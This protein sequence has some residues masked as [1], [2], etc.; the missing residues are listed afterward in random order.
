MATFLKWRKSRRDLSRLDF[1]RAV[2]FTFELRG[3]DEISLSEVTEGIIELQKKTH[4][5]YDFPEGL[6]YCYTLSE[7][8]RDL[9]S[10]GH[11]YSYEYRYDGLLPKSFFRMTHLGKDKGRRVVEK[12]SYSSYKEAIE[13]SVTT[14]IELGQNRWRLFGRKR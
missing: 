14:A 4:V 11:L 8:L 2:L 5:G 12:S 13:G 3:R 1:L 6:F 9:Q 7:D 10:A